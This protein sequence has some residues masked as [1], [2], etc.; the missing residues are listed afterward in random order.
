LYKNGKF[1]PN[2]NQDRRFKPTITPN[3]AMVDDARSVY[4]MSHL[5]YDAQQSGYDPKATGDINPRDNEQTINSIE[6]VYKSFT[7]K[8]E[9]NTFHL[10][11]D[12]EQV[13]YIF[14]K[15]ENKDNPRFG[16]TNGLISYNGDI[17]YATMGEG[18]DD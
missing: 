1:E 2:D 3:I 11:T 5:I 13:S 8:F 16:A 9:P 12:S 17:L 4:D 7:S 14:A 18:T 15:P 10:N 6:N